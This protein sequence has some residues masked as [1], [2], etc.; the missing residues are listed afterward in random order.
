[1]ISS[2]RRMPFGRNVAY[3]YPGRRI[4]K[5]SIVLEAILHGF[6]RERR[7]EHAV[8]NS[9]TCQ[10]HACI[11]QWSLIIRTLT[12]RLP[13]RKHVVASKTPCRKPMSPYVLNRCGLAR[14][15]NSGLPGWGSDKVSSHASHFPHARQ[16][17]RYVIVKLNKCSGING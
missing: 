7:K 10:Q 6:L 2:S 17:V 3:L 14:C 1:M 16:T 11:D 4:V 5:C 8:V 15:R 13:K 9:K 12:I